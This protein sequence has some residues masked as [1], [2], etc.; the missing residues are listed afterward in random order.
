MDARLL[1]MLHDAG[2]EHAL[3]VAQRVDV[4]LDRVGEIAV[5]QQRV[6]AEHG[7]DLA[8][9][10]VGIARLDVGGHQ[11]RQHAE[12]VIV[13]RGLIVDDRHRAAAE[14]VGRAHHQRQAEIGGD[15]PRLFDGIGDAVLGLLEAELVEQPLEAVAVLG[16][17]DRID[18][19]AEDRRAG[20]LDRA[21]ELQR[22]LAAELHDHALQRSRFAAPWPGSRARP[23]RSAARNRAGPRC[24]NPS[25]PSPDCN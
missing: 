9:L 17:V 2:D 21:R 25:T 10:V 7:V 12:Q 15:Q 6:L 4:D 8:G 1:D 22:R 20:L 16:E 19:R 14:H 24:R 11:A 5:E 13:E 18:R 3:A 23:P